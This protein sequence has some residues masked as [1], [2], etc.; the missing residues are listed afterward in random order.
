M[1]RK[2][3]LVIATELATNGLESGASLRVNSIH[4][5]LMSVNFEVTV[6]PRKDAKRA[7]DRNWDLVVLVSF[8]T[9]KFLRLARKSTSCLWFDPTDSWKLTRLSLIR[10][11]ELKQIFAL[12][13]DYF[14]LLRT[15]K[16]D[17]LT[18]ISKRDALKETRWVIKRTNPLIMPNIGLDRNISSSRESRF[19]FVGEGS[20]GPNKQALDYLDKVLKNLPENVEIHLF[21]NNL[22]S[23][24]PRFVV[25]GYVE[26]SDLYRK[27]DIYLAPIENG[28]GIKMKVAV[29]LWNGLRVIASPEAANGFSK[30]EGLEI[31]ATPEEFASKILAASTFGTVESLGFPAEAIYEVNQIPLLKG[32]LAA[33]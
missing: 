28:A 22:N 25:N 29:P 33:L 21:G 17:V 11:G 1:N 20:Y 14:Y 12:T 31:A 10:K 24:N 18:F 6:V 26:S 13:R 15:P 23:S 30:S 3:A 9:A 16:I 8:S 2:R 7:L 27:S 5:V 4:E 32:R 19:V